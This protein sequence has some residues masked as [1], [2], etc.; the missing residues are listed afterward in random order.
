MRITSILSIAALVAVASGAAS[1]Q[2]TGLQFGPKAGLNMSVLDG[3]INQNANF[4][5]GLLVGAFVR[6][7]PAK[8]IAIQPELVYSQ[9]GTTNKATYLGHEATDKIHLNYL[10]IPLLVKVYLGNVVNLQVGPQVGFVL[11]GQR[12]GQYGYHTGGNGD[13]YLTEDVNVSDSYKGDFALC[14][15]LGLDL[16]SGLLASIRINYG[17]SDIDN[18]SKSIAARQALGIGGVHNRTIEFSVG[19]AL[20]GKN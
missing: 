14:G 10:N 17:I 3:Q 13:G 19:Y 8:Q 9:Q 1:A 5:P 15:G 2:S 20:G 6:W 12:V 7:R 4:K 18:D 11:S 16:P